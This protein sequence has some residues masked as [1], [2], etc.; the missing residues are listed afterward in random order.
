MNRTA[1]FH[2]TSSA[3]ARTCRRYTLISWAFVLSAALLAGCSSGNGTNA[4]RGTREQVLYYANGDEPK[5]LD[6]HLTTGSPDNNIIMNLLEGLI[7]K[8]PATLEPLPGVAKSWTVS[9]D[10]RTY[11]FTL[12]ENARWS[13]GDPVTAQDFMFSWRRALT[14]TLPNE[15]AYMMFYVQGAEDFYTGVTKSF[16]DVGVK[17]LSPKVLEVTL[18]NPV[19]F[20]LQLLDHHSFYPV[21]EATIMAHGAADDPG[22]KWILP[23]NFVGNGAFV[24]KRWE[25]NKV[26]EIARNE[27]YW[28]A[29]NVRLN[30][31][32]FLPIDDQQA[33]ERAFR[34]GQVHLTN[35]PQMAI[36]KIAVY[37]K[38]RPEVLRMVPTYA[39]YY[40]M[41]N[42]N[43]KPLD[44]V[45][46]RRAISMAIDRQAIVENVT[47]GGEVPA[48]SLIPNDPEGYSPK[49]YFSYDVAAAQKLLAEAG[50][51]DGKGFPVFTVLFNSHDNHQKV[52]LA[53]QQMLK[54][55]LNIDIQLQN[56]EWKVYMDA[57]RNMEHDIARAGWV[58]DY[59]DASNFFDVMLSHSGNNHTAWVSGEYDTL[60][61]ASAATTDTEERYGLF[62]QANRILAE[63]MPIIPLYYYTDLNMV[64]TD[65]KNWH[66]NVMHYHPLRD[67]YLESSTAE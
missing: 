26:I 15:Y 27:H 65:V 20:F 7:I 29:A 55:N 59:V 14:P 37:K 48:F 19:H 6:P 56:N 11:Q 49:T 51:P 44:D 60:V 30:G 10:G 34:S 24:L 50:F 1:R 5:S 2:K 23:E 64:S 13:N 3:R 9:E 28:N 36:E 52:A 35:T 18:K 25:V 16:D 22:N 12:R 63:D 39:S 46:V 38:E 61:A 53:I 32:H 45:R 8:D 41:F 31:A 54:K 4:E 57:R 62:E 17:A 66:D 43:K 67:V 42:L 58:A 21:H 47:K 40:Y 33:E